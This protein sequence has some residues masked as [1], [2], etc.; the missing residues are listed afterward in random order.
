VKCKPLDVAEAQAETQ[1][2]LKHSIQ[3]E[4]QTS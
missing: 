1:K 3:L 2:R 4:M